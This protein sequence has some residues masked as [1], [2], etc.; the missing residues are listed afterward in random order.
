MFFAVKF[1]QPKMKS[2]SGGFQSSAIT[3]TH[4]HI[5]IFFSHL[6][7]FKLKSALSSLQ[8]TMLCIASSAHQNDTMEKL[9]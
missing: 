8:Q 9:A 6:Q 3:L 7:V 5:R 4:T 1:V 2:T